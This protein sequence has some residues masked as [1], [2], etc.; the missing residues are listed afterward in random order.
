M[1][2][3]L[4]GDSKITLNKIWKLM[5]ENNEIARNFNSFFFETI[6]DSFNLFICFSQFNVSDDKVQGII[7]NHP[8]IL[9]IKE[10]CQLN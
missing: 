8:G 2:T 6:T 10:K 1:Q 9:K 3:I 7:L 5:S 4:F